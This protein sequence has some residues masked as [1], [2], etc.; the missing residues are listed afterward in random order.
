MADKPEDVL[1]TAA[2]DG[3]GDAPAVVDSGVGLVAG[4]GCWTAGRLCVDDELVGAT[5]DSCSWIS[6]I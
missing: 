5:A 2:G 6:I 1:A 3:G 4:C